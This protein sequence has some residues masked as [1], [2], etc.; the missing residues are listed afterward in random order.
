MFRGPF[1]SQ[2]VQRTFCVVFL[3]SDHSA[4]SE[5]QVVQSLGGRP[6]IADA[7]TCIVKVRMKHGVSMLQ[8]AKPGTT[9][10]TRIAST[11]L[12][13]PHRASSLEAIKVAPRVS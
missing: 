1:R 3:V 2:A 6:E 7:D 4:D 12:G 8:H 10:K 5:Y 9:A 11:R 13:W